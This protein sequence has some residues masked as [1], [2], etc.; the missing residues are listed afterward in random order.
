MIYRDGLILLNTNL[1]ASLYPKSSFQRSPTR[2]YRISFVPVIISAFIRPVP[3][4]VTFQPQFASHKGRS[5]RSPS[6][7]RQ[8]LFCHYLPRTKIKP[9]RDRANRS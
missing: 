7:A 8:K 4:H 3:E 5:P 1:Y 2:V 9:V 6:S